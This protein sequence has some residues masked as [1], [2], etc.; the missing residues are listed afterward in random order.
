MSN[1]CPAFHS[2]YAVRAQCTQVKYSS[3]GLKYILKLFLWVFLPFCTPKCIF[4]TSHTPQTQFLSLHTSFAR[5]SLCGLWSES[6]SRHKTRAIVRLTSVVSSHFAL[7]VFQHLK[8]GIS[9]TLSCSLTLQSYSGTPYSIL[10]GIPCYF[11]SGSSIYQSFFPGLF[12]SNLV[13]SIHLSQ[14]IIK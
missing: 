7:P 11:V 14:S 9:Y 3:E 12:A 6:V 2:F 5:I 1:F 10:A 8:I 4:Q 13:F